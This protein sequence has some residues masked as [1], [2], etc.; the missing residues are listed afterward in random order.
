[1]IFKTIA[2]VK[3][4]NKG[5]GN[6]WFSA[7]TMRFFHS[8]IESRLIG[9]QY[10]ISSERMELTLPKRYSVRSV[11]DDGGISTVGVFQGYLT[12]EDARIAIDQLKG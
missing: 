9:G 3:K 2:D 10:F 4:A 11:E 1:M 6:H 12:V 7:A 8:C 5:I